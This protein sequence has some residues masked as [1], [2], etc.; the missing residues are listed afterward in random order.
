[1]PLDCSL[2]PHHLLSTCLGRKALG[3]NRKFA[4]HYPTLCLQQTKQTLQDNTL[5]AS[6]HLFVRICEAT[7]ASQSA[8][9]ITERTLANSVFD[10]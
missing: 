7:D 6:A 4:M 5:C 2:P 1:M 9:D 8:D 3:I 10:C